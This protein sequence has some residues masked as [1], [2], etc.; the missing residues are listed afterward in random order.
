MNPDKIR[1]PQQI[2]RLPDLP[3]Q[4]LDFVEFLLWQQNP[5][6]AAQAWLNTDISNLGTYKPYAWAEGELEKDKHIKN[7]SARPAQITKYWVSQNLQKHLVQ[8]CQPTF[9][10]DN[11]ICCHL[12]KHYHWPAEAYEN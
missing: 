4:V 2:D 12:P 7:T 1:L 5:S 10:C 6:P 8:L 9:H 11:G 3:R